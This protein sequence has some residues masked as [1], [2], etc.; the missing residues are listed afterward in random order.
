L[1]DYGG[2]EKTDFYIEIRSL[3][4]DLISSSTTDAVSSLYG[5]TAQS[6]AINGEIFKNEFKDCAFLVNAT[7]HYHVAITSARKCI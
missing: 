7:Q 6:E 1:E 4:R 5:C 2:D 3:I